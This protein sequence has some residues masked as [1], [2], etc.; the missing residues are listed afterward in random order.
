MHRRRT[1]A[2]AMRANAAFVAKV[3]A[4]VDPVPPHG[5]AEVLNAV[6]RAVAGV[7]TRGRPGQRAADAAPAKH[8]SETVPAW[9]PGDI[10]WAA[11]GREFPAVELR[12]GCVI[13]GGELA[14]NTAL[15]EAN[16][17]QLVELRDLLREP[18]SDVV[19]PDDDDLEAPF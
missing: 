12:D 9:T 8:S 18:A 14:W 10:F 5:Q 2:L 19:E 1:E 16:A 17:D 3:V 13:A 6:R 7:V 11:K 4:L 15:D